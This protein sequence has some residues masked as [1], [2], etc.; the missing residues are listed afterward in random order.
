MNR[1]IGYLRVSKPQQRHDRQ[2]DGLEGLC[3]ELHVEQ[4]SGAG[5]S[6]PIY[7]GVIA[8]LRPGDLL[9][10]LDLDRAFRSAADALNEIEKLH[11]QGINIHIANFHV[12][13][14]TPTGYFIYTVMSGLAE[15]ERRTLSQRTKEG[16]EAARRRGKRLGRPAKVTDRQIR[17]AKRRYDRGSDTLTDLAAGLGIHPW[18]LTRRIKKL[19]EA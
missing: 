4:I 12:D 19:Q 2:Y 7:D 8:G 13:T 9:V 14:S 3:D 1:S 10:V 6:R 15:F 17:A 5:K 18:T 16:L 11:A